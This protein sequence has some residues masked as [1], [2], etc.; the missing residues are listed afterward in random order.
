MVR[1]GEEPKRVLGF[2]LRQ[3]GPRR[4]EDEPSVLGLPRGWISPPAFDLRRIAHPLR[5]WRWRRQ[6]QRLGPYAP[7]YD[8]FGDAPE[9]N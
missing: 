3:A 5:W 2:P 7:D 9:A 1:D 4:R 6:V 8:D